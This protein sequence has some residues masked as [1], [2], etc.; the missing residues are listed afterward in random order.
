MLRGQGIRAA[1]HPDV[2]T[3]A[4]EVRVQGKHKLLGSS[5]LLT[6]AVEGTIQP[7][8]AGPLHTRGWDGDWSLVAGAAEELGLHPGRAFKYH[9]A[10]RPC[11]YNVT[12]C[13]AAWRGHINVRFHVTLI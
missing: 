4:E 8:A 6:C 10:L 5:R 3:E 1:W 7:D 9:A 13:V 11:Q 2:L 12:S